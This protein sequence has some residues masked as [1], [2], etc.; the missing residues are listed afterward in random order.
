MRLKKVNFKLLFRLISMS[1]A[2][3]GMIQA[4][5]G[6]FMYF[7]IMSQNGFLPWDLVGIR[8]MWDSKSINDLS[9]S[10]GQEWVSQH[11]QAPNVKIQI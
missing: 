6:F 2:Q 11:S 7:V 1:Y 4:V 9:D 8:K 3:I 10:Y 5:G